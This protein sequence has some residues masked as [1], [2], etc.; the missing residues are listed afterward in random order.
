MNTRTGFV[1]LAVVMLVGLFALMTLS[2]PGAQAGPLAAP[3]P[4][5]GTYTGGTLARSVTL[6]DSTVTTST[7]FG[8]NGVS[9]LTGDRIDLQ[10]VIDQPTSVNTMTL[11]LQFSNDLVNWIDG[12]TIVTDNAAD[13]NVMQQYA[14]FG[15]YARINIAGANT[16]EATVKVIGVLK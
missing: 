1:G 8:G 15:N 11:K 6:Y 14:V 5:A 9:V 12:A 4:V 16:N 2:T 10:Y 13:A 3:T 7:A